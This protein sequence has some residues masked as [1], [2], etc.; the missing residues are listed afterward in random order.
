MEKK[1]QSF[2]EAIKSL[3]E[4]GLVEEIVPGQF[5]LSSNNNT[6]TLRED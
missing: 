1:E 2:E 4:M 3:I 5:K 6:S